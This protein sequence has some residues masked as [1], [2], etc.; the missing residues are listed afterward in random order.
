VLTGRRFA[1]LLTTIDLSRPA[2]GMDEELRAAGVHPDYWCNATGFG[3][4]K[5]KAKV[6]VQDRNIPLLAV[7]DAVWAAVQN[8]RA[9]WPAD[10]A[11]EA[12]RRYNHKANRC[13]HQYA[14][15]LSSLHQARKVYAS[16]AFHY[17]NVRREASLRF[18]A[19]VLGHAYVLSGNT[20]TYLSAV[21]EDL[22][23]LSFAERHVR[24]SARKTRSPPSASLA[25]A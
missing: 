2:V 25:A 20:L 13:V 8:V 18:Y 17:L 12:D 23:S 10:T 14:P 5:R 1:E 15:F 21:L 7:R 11:S 24:R 6:D 22:G 9:H 19:N 3:K 4:K 16:I